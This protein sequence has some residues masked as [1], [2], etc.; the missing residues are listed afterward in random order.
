MLTFDGMLYTF[1]GYGEYWLVR[2]EN[3]T[4]PE[5][6]LEFALQA[7]FQQPPPIYCEYPVEFKFCLFSIYQCT[8]NVN[9]AV[10]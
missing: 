5:A 6:P 9:L 3:R 7:R 2:V 4:H 8:H 10:Q 1:N